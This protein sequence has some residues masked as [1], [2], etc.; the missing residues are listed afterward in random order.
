M[1]KIEGIRSRGW[2]RM[3]W[4]DGI[5]NLMDI[6]LSK[7]QELVMDREAWRAAVHG[8]SKSRI[9]LRHWTELNL[10]SRWGLSS[11]LADSHRY[12][13]SSHGREREEAAPCV[14]F[15]KELIPLS[16]L[17]INLI[18]SQSAQLQILLHCELGP[19]VVSLGS[20][21]KLSVH[22]IIWPSNST[23][24]Y[25]LQRDKNLWSQS[26]SINIYSVHVC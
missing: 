19:Q 17:Y 16:W 8:V 21:Q 12:P 6:S 15:I 23:S 13:L 22:K 18:T 5:T 9:R 3:R 11:W 25:L 1:G 14:S 24:R 4:L 20:G 2:Q 26:L 7:L 10:V